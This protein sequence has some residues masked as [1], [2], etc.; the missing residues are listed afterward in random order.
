MQ[1]FMCN[2]LIW[3]TNLRLREISGNLLAP[4][5]LQSL[6]RCGVSAFG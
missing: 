2:Q 1:I 4:R 6:P 3:K 5:L